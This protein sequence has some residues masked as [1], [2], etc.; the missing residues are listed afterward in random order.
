MRKSTIARDALLAGAALLILAAL[1][2]V[3]PGKSFSDF[4]IRCHTPY[5]PLAQP[6]VGYGGMV[7]FG[8]AC[9]SLGAYSSRC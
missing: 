8:T 5:S 1:P 4:V 2:L 6:L 7:S 9:H 3:F